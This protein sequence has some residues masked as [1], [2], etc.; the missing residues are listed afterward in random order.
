[1]IIMRQH[2]EELGAVLMAVLMGANTVT[3]VGV[4]DAPVHAAHGPLSFSYNK[5]SWCTVGA[6]TMQPLCVQL[7]L[8]A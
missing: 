8:V 6:P 3:A 4:H 7:L 1:M 2:R 5:T